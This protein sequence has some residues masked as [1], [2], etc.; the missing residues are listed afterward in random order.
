[1]KQTQL[2][3]LIRKEGSIMGV[4]ELNGWTK[5]FDGELTVQEPATTRTSTS[6]LTSHIIMLAATS[7][8]A[9]TSTSRAM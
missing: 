4:F 2:D 6:S 3:N 5:V 1:M 9:S 7:T 8:S